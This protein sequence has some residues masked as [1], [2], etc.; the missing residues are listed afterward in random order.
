MAHNGGCH[1]R[2]ERPLS[3]GHLT[4]RRH[5]SNFWTRLEGDAWPINHAPTPIYL[6]C[7]S[8]Y[9][10]RPGR[11]I[12]YGLFLASIERYAEAEQV[13]EEAVE[14]E[15]R[16][17]GPASAAIAYRLVDL[18]KVY[19]EQS[20]WPATRGCWR[21]AEAAPRMNRKPPSGCGNQRA[22]DLDPPSSGRKSKSAKRL[23]RCVVAGGPWHEFDLQTPCSFGC[24]RGG[25]ISLSKIELEIGFP[26]YFENEQGLRTSLPRAVASAPLAHRRRSRV[27]ASCF[28]GE[29][30][31][32]CAAA[33]ERRRPARTKAAPLR[34][35]RFLPRVSWLST[36]S[37]VR[38]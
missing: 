30:N 16:N 22:R 7:L 23:D 10:T 9:F 29:P 21:M 24:W 27:L 18:A 3:G 26:Y 17:S 15:E 38:E 12:R 35:Y 13:L 28:V 36:Q 31:C 4:F 8:A 1:S 5:G 37:L 20:R 11:S 34:R 25:R 14:T 6:T 33:V 19:N 32:R 2:L